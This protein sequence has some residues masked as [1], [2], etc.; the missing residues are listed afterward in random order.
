MI[1]AYEECTHNSEMQAMKKLVKVY[2]GDCSSL[3]QLSTALCRINGISEDE[4]FVL[5]TEEHSAA[6]IQYKSELYLFS[7]TWVEKLSGIELFLL[8]RYKVTGFYNDRYYSKKHVFITKKGLSRAGTLKE[9]LESR[10]GIKFNDIQADYP[11]QN[12]EYLTRIALQEKSTDIVDIIN[13]SVR[14]PLLKQKCDENATIDDMVDW[15]N[16]NIDSK[17]LFSYDAFMTPDQV[18]VFKTAGYLDKAIFLWCY[19]RNKNIPCEVFRNNEA[20]C[21][22]IDNRIFL[23]EEKIT[24]SDNTSGNAIPPGF[25]PMNRL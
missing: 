16:Q 15:I 3:S 18:I 5:R 19:C 8:N 9:K 13:S 24:G 2:A 25:M 4:I 6:I 1:C 14:G 22:R 12:I 10:Y 21:L 11:Q 7:N 17:P 23:I 20:C